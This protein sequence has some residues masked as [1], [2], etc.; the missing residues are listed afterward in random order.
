MAESGEGRGGEGG[1]YMAT[2]RGLAAEMEEG[3][4]N[5][6]C[7]HFVPDFSISDAHHHMDDR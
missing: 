1:R 3:G 4:L 5:L 2:L 7:T 6:S